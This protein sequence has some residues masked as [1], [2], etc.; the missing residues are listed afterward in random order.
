VKYSR[1][2]TVRSE[3][4]K[5]AIVLTHKRFDSFQFIRT[6]YNEITIGPTVI[7]T[8]R[9]EYIVNIC[10]QQNIADCFQK[11]VS[12]GSRTYPSTERTMPA[13][14]REENAHEIRCDDD[15]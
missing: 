12:T 13:S 4:L 6:A 5:A 9:G 3:I 7:E 11:T 1:P 14:A 10:V 2:S 15:P 8:F